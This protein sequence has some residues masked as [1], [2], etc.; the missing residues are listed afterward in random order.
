MCS[1]KPVVWVGRALEDLK[2][3]PREVQRVFGNAL[4]QAQQGSKHSNAKPWKGLSGVFEIVER[5][6]TDAYR[7]IY[8]VKFEDTVYVLHVFQKKSKI[9]R[10]TQL[11]DI[12]I[13]NNRYEEARLIHTARMEGR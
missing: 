4:D 6:R 7:A 2:R 12:Q 1:R 11:R 10:K 5:Y 3:C 9:G 13:I 8:T